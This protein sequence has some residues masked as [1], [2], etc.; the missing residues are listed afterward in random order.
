MVEFNWVT[1][2]IGGMLSGLGATLLLATTGR[3][4]GVSGI[5]NGAM[6][7]KSTDKSWRWLFLLGLVVGG[8]SY[9]YFVASTPTPTYGLLPFAMIV[10][11]F[12]SGFGARMGNG[13]TSGHGICGLG[14][15]SPRSLAAVLTFV[16]AA[17][18]T[19]FVVRNLLGG[20]I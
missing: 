8:A 20:I 9:E 4:A 2:L 18:V 17:I 11:G 10:G 14:R 1:A 19:V 7:P 3:I 6:S 5:L 13:C 15:L 12:V 16:T